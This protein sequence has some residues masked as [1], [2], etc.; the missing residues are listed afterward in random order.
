VGDR[1]YVF[2]GT[3]WGSMHTPN[4]YKVILSLT[5]ASSTFCVIL[6]SYQASIYDGTGW[7]HRIEVDPA[8]VTSIS[9]PT[10]SFCAAVDIDGRGLFYEG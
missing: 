10:S 8:R 4:G 5:C 7:S 2:D 1:V 6:F 3:S 9:C